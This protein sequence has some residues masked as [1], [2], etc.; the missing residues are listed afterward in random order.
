MD[1]NA[2]NA[3]RKTPAGFGEK[4]I[5]GVFQKEAVLYLRDRMD[6]KVF[7]AVM[8]SDEGR[9]LPHVAAR[10]YLSPSDWK[11]YVWIEQHGS[12]EGFAD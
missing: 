12:L 8:R 11:R 3:R 9:K 4:Y 7:D 10:I 1:L 2:K 6:R 5:P